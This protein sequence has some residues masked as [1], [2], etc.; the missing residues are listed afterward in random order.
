MC[1]LSGPQEGLGDE[2][3]QLHTPGSHS[4]AFGALLHPGA[5]EWHHSGTVMSE[6]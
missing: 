6:P 1:A 2:W 5:D 4:K 3:Q